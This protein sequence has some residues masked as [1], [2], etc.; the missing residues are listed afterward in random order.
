MNL[1]EPNLHSVIHNHVIESNWQVENIFASLPLCN[2]IVAFVFA[3]HQERYLV[4]IYFRN[5]SKI[6][7]EW[8]YPV[9]DAYQ[10]C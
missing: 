4:E 10:D 9:R 5:D 1:P 8:V 7:G 2:L 6:S 3:D